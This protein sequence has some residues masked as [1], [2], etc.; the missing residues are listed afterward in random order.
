MQVDEGEVV[1]YGKKGLALDYTSKG[2]KCGSCGVIK[3][4]DNFHNNHSAHDGKQT[5]CKACKHKYDRKYQKRKEAQGVFKRKRRYKRRRRSVQVEP[6]SMI[7]V[8]REHDQRMSRI[9]RV[10]GI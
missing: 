5:S 9:E 4:L 10:L 6:K 1:P 2:K 3:S 8:L 7:N